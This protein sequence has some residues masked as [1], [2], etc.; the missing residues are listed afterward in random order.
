MKMQCLFNLNS[1]SSIATER[2]CSG[3]TY[4]LC[5]SVSGWFIELRVLRG[6]CMLAFVV[7]LPTK[8][9]QWDSELTLQSHICLLA[10]VMLW[11]ALLCRWW[12]PSFYWSPTIHLDFGMHWLWSF[13]CC[14]QLWFSVSEC[15]WN[16]EDAEMIGHWSVVSFLCS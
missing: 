15:V 1:P 14:A 7:L 8:A 2:C 9:S 12:P 6:H 5:T 10:R 4:T 11:K 3:C 16:I 13:S